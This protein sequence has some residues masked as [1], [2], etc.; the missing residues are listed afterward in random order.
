M[1]PV[2]VL[3]K[4]REPGL[5]LDIVERSAYTFQYCLLPWRRVERIRDQTGVC[6]LAVN[7]W[8]FA[9]MIWYSRV[10]ARPVTILPVTIA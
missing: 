2:E 6:A 8:V 5:K 3:Q 1:L 9:G 4:R 10:L 7:F